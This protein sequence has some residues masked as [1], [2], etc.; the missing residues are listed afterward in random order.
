[1]KSDWFNVCRCFFHLSKFRKP[2]HSFESGFLLFCWPDTI[3][4]M[5]EH[6][7]SSSSSSQGLPENLS[8]PQLIDPPFWQ[9]GPTPTQTVRHWQAQMHQSD[10]S[11]R[12]SYRTPTPASP[13][14]SELTNQSS[15]DDHENNEENE[16]ERVT[17]NARL[18]RYEL[19]PRPNR[20]NTDMAT[21][22]QHGQHVQP[23]DWNL[24][25]AEVGA[26]LHWC[27]FVKAHVNIFKLA[28]D[29]FQGTPHRTM[30]E[31]YKLLKL[32]FKCKHYNAQRELKCKIAV[33]FGFREESCYLTLPDETQHPRNKRK[34]RLSSEIRET[35]QRFLQMVTLSDA[36]DFFSLIGRSINHFATALRILYRTVKQAHVHRR[37]REQVQLFLVRTLDRCELYHNRAVTRFY[38]EVKHVSHSISRRY[39]TPPSAL[40]AGCLNTGLWIAR[41]RRARQM[42]VA[43]Q[44]RQDRQFYAV[45]DNW[46]G[47]YR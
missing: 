10:A 9:N 47:N 23:S 7:T 24:L 25:L 3:S 22:A 2:L 45:P 26:F 33:L 31:E 12:T 46:V 21:E 44:Q 28:R 36:V 30:K 13:G 29:S 11:T 34:E 19:E 14:D 35:N 17:L 43:Q 5:N 6:E 39:R 32:L 4:T 27:Q 16:Q 15:R 41:R 1:M 40:I 20:I 37:N 42:R 18:L 8:E 38:R